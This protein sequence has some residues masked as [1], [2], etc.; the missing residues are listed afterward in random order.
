MSLSGWLRV[1]TTVF[2]L[3]L[4]QH[5]IPTCLKT[6]AIIPIPLKSPSTCLNDFWPTWSALRH[7]DIG[8]HQRLHTY[9]QPTSI[10]L[11]SNCFKKIAKKTDLNC[12]KVIMNWVWKHS[13][14]NLNSSSTLT[15]STGVHQGCVLSS[16]PSLPMTTCQFTNPTSQL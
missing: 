5:I 1:F 8:P 4:S 3:S 14:R 13:T 11:P 16:T 7:W 15:L 2:N 10:C 9:T 12:K 6:T